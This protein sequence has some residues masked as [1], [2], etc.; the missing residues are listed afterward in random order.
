MPF[1]ARME[2]DMYNQIGLPDRIFILQADFSVLRKRKDNLG[3]HQH[4]AKSRAVNNIGAT[5]CI[6]PVN[7]DRPYEDVLAE[8]KRAIWRVLS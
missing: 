5:E 4:L 8:L 1:L 6:V 3:E 2:K 7:V